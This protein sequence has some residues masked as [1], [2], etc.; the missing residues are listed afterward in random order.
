MSHLFSTSASFY[1]PLAQ[2]A[3]NTPTLIA[4]PLFSPQPL[5]VINPISSPLPLLPQNSFQLTV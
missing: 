3:S 1:H 5:P 4:P 2:S